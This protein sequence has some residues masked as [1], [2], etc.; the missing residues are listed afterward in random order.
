MILSLL[1]TFEE[2]PGSSAPASDQFHQSLTGLPQFLCHTS[3]SCKRPQRS[4]LAVDKVTSAVLG[5][6]IWHSTVD[7]GLRSDLTWH[8]KHPHDHL[9]QHPEQERVVDCPAALNKTCRNRFQIL[10]DIKMDIQT[11][12]QAERHKFISPGCTA[13]EVTPLPSVMLA[14][15]WLK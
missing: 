8:K 3:V 13:Q 7:D 14:S 12:I 10:R 5:S 4:W 9:H 15:S 11:L 1:K 2:I 6:F